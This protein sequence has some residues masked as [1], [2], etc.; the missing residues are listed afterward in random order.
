M[1]LTGSRRLVHRRAFNVSSIVVSRGRSSAASYSSPVPRSRARHGEDSIQ[2]TGAAAHAVVDA[3]STLM[4][5]LTAYGIYISPG[6]RLSAAGSSDARF[7]GHG[8]AARVT[9]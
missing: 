6:R 5:L 2:S 9:I 7:V 1:Q 4:C 3:T 8:E